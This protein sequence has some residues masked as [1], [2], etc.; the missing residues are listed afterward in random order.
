MHCFNHN[1]QNAIG[2]CC[3]CN[4]GICPKCADTNEKQY[5]LCKEDFCRETIDAGKQIAVRTK[6]IY[7]IGKENNNKLPVMGIFYI[8]FGI[9]F[10]GFS[11]YRFFVGQFDSVDAFVFMMGVPIIFLGLYVLLKKDKLNC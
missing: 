1:T 11:G 7:G 8:F 4:K 5:L 3:I 10:W 2:T 9:I 6:K